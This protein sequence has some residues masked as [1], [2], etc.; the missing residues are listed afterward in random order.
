MN[1]LEVEV[2]VISWFY[3]SGDEVK[4]EQARAKRQFMGRSFG[5][6][7][8]IRED[9]DQGFLAFIGPPVELDRAEAEWVPGEGATRS[10]PRPDIMQSLAYEWLVGTGGIVVDG[11]GGYKRV[12]MPR[13]GDQHIA[14][15]DNRQYE[16]G[17][18]E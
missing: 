3:E 6:R 16:G 8:G 9:A 11:E 12:E 5:V 2:G 18:D 13:I 4:A 1:E 14:D 15:G 17:D 7:A 10:D